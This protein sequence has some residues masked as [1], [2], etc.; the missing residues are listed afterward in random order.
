MN[1]GQ[2]SRA[3]GI[4]AKMIRWYEQQGLIPAA[5]RSDSNYRNYSETD[6][7]RLRFIRRARDLGFSIKQI[8]ELLTLWNDRGRA[9]ADVKVLALR[10]VEAMQQRIRELEEM[11][12]TLTH[13]AE[14]CHG[15][16]RP[17]CPIL[18]ELGAA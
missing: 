3:T 5:T 1:I 14:N 8:S 11:V 7:H 12:G 15:D 17:E 10:H 16:G 9:S 2:A 4:S 6:L 13:L 18:E